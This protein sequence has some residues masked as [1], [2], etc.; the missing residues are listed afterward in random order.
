MSGPMYLLEFSIFQFEIWPFCTICLRVF[1][2]TCK[3]PIFD[4]VFGMMRARTQMSARFPLDDFSFL[5]FLIFYIKFV[6]LTQSFP[7]H[8]RFLK[9]F[10]KKSYII[11]FIQAN[12][13]LRCDVLFTTFDKGSPTSK[14]YIEDRQSQHRNEEVKY[15][16]YA[17]RPIYL[18]MSL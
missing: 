1:F 6:R 3:W 14:R 4:L 12:Y 15:F 7:M 8:N 11:L 18:V 17:L 13:F 10:K 9:P 16:W 5:F 2:C